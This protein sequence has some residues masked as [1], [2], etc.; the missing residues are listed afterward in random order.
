MFPVLPVL[1]RTALKVKSFSLIPDP[2]ALD[3]LPSY[4]LAAVYAVAYPFCHY[5][6][7]A[8]VSE[9]GVTSPVAALWKIAHNGITQNMQ[10][11]RLAVLQ[12]ML[13]CLQGSAGGIE[14]AT[15]DLPESWLMLGSAVQLANR[16]GMHVD[17][18]GWGIPIWEKRLRRRLWWSLYCEATWRSLLLGLPHPIQTSQWDVSPPH[19][20]D[21]FIDDLQCPTEATSGLAP[22]LQRLCLFCHSAR[23]FK[24]LAD[25]TVI[26]HD[27]HESCYTLSATKTLSQDR[28]ASQT[29]GKRLLARLKEWKLTIPSRIASDNGLDCKDQEYFHCS[30]S[31][32]LKLCHL[33]LETF[34]Y[35]SMIRPAALASAP[36]QFSKS[37]SMGHQTSTL[38]NHAEQEADLLG[39]VNFGQATHN[40]AYRGAIKLV[41]RACLFAQRL[42]SY[43]RGNFI[44]E[45]KSD[46]LS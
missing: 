46:H 16:Q 19:D 22:D 29:T 10:S 33:T 18:Q 45:C 20:D 39:G 2:T 42:T 31:A 21:F 34:V 7:V 4:L 30:S 38:S 6:A 13:L 27:I 35:R 12:T 23:D 15:A 37:N 25:L 9:V 24:H 8:S 43:D 44:F 26:A 11:S 28:H 1:S 32:Y 41:H 40:E 14:M 17:C 3:T 5:D 36:S